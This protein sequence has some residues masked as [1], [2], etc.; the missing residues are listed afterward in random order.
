MTFFY[1]LITMMNEFENHLIEY[2]KNMKY[3]KK[4]EIQV[5]YFVFLH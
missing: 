2:L 3:L 1:V 5:Q 4:L